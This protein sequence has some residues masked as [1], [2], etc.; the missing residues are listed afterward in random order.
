MKVKVAKIK[1]GQSFSCIQ[2]FHFVAGMFTERY[3]HFYCRDEFTETNLH[4]CCRD[5]FTERN[6]HFCCRD[7]FTE[8]YLHFCCRDEFT[9]RYLHSCCRDEFSKRTLHFVTGMN[10]QRD[11]Y[12]LIIACRDEFRKKLTLC[13]WGQVYL[14]S[15]VVV[16]LLGLNTVKRNKE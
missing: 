13:C 11:I 2:Y 10:F 16:Q 5:E 8:R 6:L 14:T 12:T 9:E 4:F 7:E 15:Q 1:W 3:L